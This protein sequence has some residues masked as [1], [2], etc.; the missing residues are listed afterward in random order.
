MNKTFPLDEAC[1]RTS[2]EE[3]N[4]LQITNKEVTTHVTSLLAIFLGPFNMSSDIILH[5]INNCN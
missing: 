4:Y 5:I 2:V 3:A 1:D